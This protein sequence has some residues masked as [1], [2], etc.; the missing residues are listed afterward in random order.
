ML[1]APMTTQGRIQHGKHR[2]NLRT[3]FVLLSS[4]RHIYPILDHPNITFYPI[5]FSNEN[6]SE[7]LSVMKTRV[8]VL[9]KTFSDQHVRIFTQ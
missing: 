3:E 2:K 8:K 6:K 7:K 5:A 9:L 1:F 4:I